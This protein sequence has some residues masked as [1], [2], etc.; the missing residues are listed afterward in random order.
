M[1]ERSW[2]SKLELFLVIDICGSDICEGQ[3]QKS[4]SDKKL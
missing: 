4:P 2:L 1:K 3:N